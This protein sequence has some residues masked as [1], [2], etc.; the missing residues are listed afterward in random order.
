MKARIKGFD[1]PFRKVETVTMKGVNGTYF[2]EDV[3]FEQELQGESALE[4]V[5]EEKIDNLISNWKFGKFGK[6][7]NKVEPKFKLDDFIVY[8]DN[9]WK[10]CNIALQSY[11]ELLKINNEVSTISIEDVDE[12]AHLWAIKD[13][14]DGDVLVTGNKNIF[15]FKSIS[16]YTIYDYCG[17]YFEK[18]QESPS[19]VNGTAA[20]KL[21]VDYIPATKEQRNILFQK[22]KEAGYEWDAEKKE[23]IKL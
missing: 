22:M 11:Y 23:L 4:A 14:K 8:K 19:T 3:E 5:N 9:I 10:V 13:A 1:G 12:N 2:A 17:L 15:I 7:T 20:E 16:G 6:P 18:F 21:P